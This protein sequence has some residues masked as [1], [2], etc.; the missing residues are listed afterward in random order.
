MVAHTLASGA[1]RRERAWRE[2]SIGDGTRARFGER[3][4]HV[5]AVT[6]S[7]VRGLSAVMRSTACSREPI[8]SRRDVPDF[9]FVSLPYPAIFT[10]TAHHPNGRHNIGWYNLTAWIRSSGTACLRR[11]ASPYD[12]FITSP[13]SVAV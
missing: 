6:C 12:R 9:L 11:L 5:G 2:A 7:G 10:D 1:G 13:S 3:I 8:G 4:S